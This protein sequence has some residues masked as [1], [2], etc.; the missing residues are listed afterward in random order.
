VPGCLPVAVVGESRRA[1]VQG[2]YDATGYPV[3]SLPH[4]GNLGRRPNYSYEKRQ[5][6]LKKQKK[7][8]AKLAKKQGRPVDAADSTD[9]ADERPTS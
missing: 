3:V 9:S 6:E 4:G 1:R 5:R 7:K 2:R 8:E